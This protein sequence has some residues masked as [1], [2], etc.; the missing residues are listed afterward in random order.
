MAKYRATRNT[1]A[2]IQVP[3]EDQIERSHRYEAIQD[4]IKVDGLQYETQNWD[5]GAMEWRD[6]SGAMLCSRQRASGFGCGVGYLLA[7]ADG[8]ISLGELWRDDDFKAAVLPLL[9]CR[10]GAHGR[11]GW[12][13]S[14]LICI[15]TAQKAVFQQSGTLQV[16]REEFII[17]ECGAFPNYTHG[18]HM[19]HLY[20]INFYPGPKANYPVGHDRGA[21]KGIASQKRKE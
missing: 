19:M 15:T 6:W 1:K 11:C 14:S 10:D 7:E 3:T 13:G 9:Q 4:F 5:S 2:F 12:W 18:P 16:M 17:H 21:D 8:M 20:A